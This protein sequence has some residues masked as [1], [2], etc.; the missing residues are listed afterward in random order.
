MYGV[1]LV[2]ISFCRLLATLALQSF[3]GCSCLR[4][5]FLSLLTCCRGFRT[6]SGTCELSFLENDSVIILFVLALEFC[7]CGRI[8]KRGTVRGEEKAGVSCALSDGVFMLQ[9]LASGAEVIVTSLCGV[10][11]ACLR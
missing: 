10:A 11:A 6:C 7:S 3:S 4:I 2:A 1:N 9:A 8:S 5:V